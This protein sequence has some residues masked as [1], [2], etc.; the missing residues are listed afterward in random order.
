MKILSTCTLPWVWIF[1][2]T[3]KRYFDECWIFWSVD[4]PHWLP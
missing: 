1:C 4:G 2:W 3:Q